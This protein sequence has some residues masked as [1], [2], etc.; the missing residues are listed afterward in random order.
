MV[1]QL[2]VANDSVD[3]SA[4]E[5]HN[6]EMIA[7]VDGDEVPTERPEMDDSDQFQGDYNKLK[8]SYDALRTK[9]DSGE[10]D[11]PVDVQEELGIPQD[12]EVAEGKFDIAE[13]T[14]EYTDN[15]GLSDKSYKQLEDGGI[16]REMANQYIAGQKALGEQIGNQ[17][18]NEVGGQE[19]YGSM[20]D[21]AKSNYSA[22]QIKAYDDAVNSGNIELAKMA[23]RGLKAD[24]SNKVGTEGETYGG[25]PTAPEGAADVFRSNAEVTTAMK[26][27]RYEYDTAFRADVLNKL[28]RSDIFSQGKL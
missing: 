25:K 8:Q 26:D 14:Q 11:V 27:P 28:D 6:Q 4:E 1:D 13:L 2:T 20:V 15:G 21:W 5:Q 10:A 9:M 12:P 17:V 18:K 23:A 7:K 24:Y 19:E 3:L 22:D 16:S